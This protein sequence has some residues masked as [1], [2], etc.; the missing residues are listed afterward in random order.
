[1][2]IENYTEYKLSSGI[3]KKLEFVV[4]TLMKSK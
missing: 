2:G 4:V 1:M 3:I